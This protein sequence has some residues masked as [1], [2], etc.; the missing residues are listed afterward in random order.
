MYKENDDIIVNLTV[1]QNCYAACKDC[2]NRSLTFAGSL[3]DHR[4]E[5][6]G[7][8]AEYVASLV[9][10]IAAKYPERGLTLCFY[11]GEPFLE[12]GRME[13]IRMLLNA[14]SA[15]GRIKY[16]VYSNGDLI[17]DAAD[18]YPD[19]IKGIWLYSLSIDGSRRQHEQVRP[20]TSLTRIIDSLIKLRS[21]SDGHILVWS[22]LREEQSLMDCFRQFISMHRYG[23]ADHFFWHFADAGHPYANFKDYA[24]KYEEELEQLM[25]HYISWLSDGEI[26]PVAHINEL[27]LYLLEGRKRGHTACAVELA[28]N[29]DIQGGKVHACA[30][31]PSRLGAYSASGSIEISPAVLQ[32]L[33]AYREKLGCRNCKM[34]FYCGGRCP[35]QALAGSPER[36]EQ[37]CKLIHIHVT[38]VKRHLS[39][40]V[41]MLSKYRITSQQIYDRSAFIAR[42]TDVI[43]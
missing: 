39:F 33:V 32:S 29:Y 24:R 5:E 28:E 15:A 30:D 14:T 3:P 27:L 42:Y 13:K 38:T 20:G 40:I 37:I 43:P 2:I 8:D 17:G 16:M 22:T 36:T 11:G 23:I 19:L 34:D 10:Q 25:R 9:R 35:V 4:I 1:T 18:N 26:L 6:S 31:L 41:R 7:F 12:P 21:M